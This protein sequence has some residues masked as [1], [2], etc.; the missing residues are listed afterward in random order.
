M[1]RIALTEPKMALAGVALEASLARFMASMAVFNN[2]RLPSRRRWEFA[3]M[4]E[5]GG[6]CEKR[7]GRAGY[8]DASAP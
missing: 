6:S 4:V 2:E 7:A 8:E 1:T 3:F 5:S